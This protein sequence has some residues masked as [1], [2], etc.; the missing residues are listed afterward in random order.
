MAGNNGMKT[1]K[2]QNM[3]LNVDAASVARVSSRC[4]ARGDAWVRQ[5]VHHVNLDKLLIYIKKEERCDRCDT[6]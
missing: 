1:A 4:E 6:K 3:K 2:M 5:A